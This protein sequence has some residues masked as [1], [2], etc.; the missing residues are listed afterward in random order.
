MTETETS[1]DE[2]CLTIITTLHPLCL[3]SLKGQHSAPEPHLEKVCMRRSSGACETSCTKNDVDL[4]PPHMLPTLWPQA[5]L[6][7]RAVLFPTSC[8]PNFWQ[9]HEP[10][11]SCMWNHQWREVSSPALLEMFCLWRRLVKPLL[12]KPSS[13]M[14]EVS[15]REDKS[16]IA[17]GRPKTSCFWDHTAETA[18][19]KPSDQH[20]KWPSQWKMNLIFKNLFCHYKGTKMLLQRQGWVC[21][22]WYPHWEEPAL[23]AEQRVPCNMKGKFD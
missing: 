6:T 14:G 3:Q 13:S 22:L 19:K 9:D 8:T 10:Q 17:Q 23:A 1:M 11:P 18:S 7:H 2:V 5:S 4:V 16:D 20:S 12:A 21:R 15:W